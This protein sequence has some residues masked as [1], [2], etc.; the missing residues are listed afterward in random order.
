MWL[1]IRNVIMANQ[2]ISLITSSTTDPRN[3]KYHIAQ[4]HYTLFELDSKLS[5][6]KNTTI[7]DLYLL[8]NIEGRVGNDCICRYTSTCHMIVATETTKLSIKQD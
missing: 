3:A 5:V 7:I 6:I 8:T 1:G 2:M 4:V